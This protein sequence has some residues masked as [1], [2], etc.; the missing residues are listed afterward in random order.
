[1]RRYPNG[2]G[3]GLQ[4]HYSPVRLWPC[5]PWKGGRVR[6]NAPVSKTDVAVSIPSP[7]VR[8]PPLPPR[9]SP[10]M[11]LDSSERRVVKVGF[12]C[13]GTPLR[14]YPGRR[15]DVSERRV[16]AFLVQWLG[17]SPC[18]GEVG[19][20]FLGSAQ[21]AGVKRLHAGLISQRHRV[22]LPSAPPSR[23][24]ERKPDVSP[25]PGRRSGE[26]GDRSSTPHH[27]QVA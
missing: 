10:R 5:A 6:I 20:R 16:H 1:M 2:Q 13:F 21:C 14:G 8:I 4:P 26:G 24:R 9:E 18:T 11:R 27:G 25:V 15:L 22:R 23:H 12:E 17:R 19:V 7:W 3:S